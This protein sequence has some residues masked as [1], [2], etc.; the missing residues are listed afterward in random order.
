MLYSSF[1]LASYFT[2][3]SLC[4]SML[5]SQFVP[6]SLSGITFLWE[7]FSASGT[8]PPTLCLAISAP[9]SLCVPCRSDP[10]VLIQL[11][12]LP[13][14]L[15]V[16]IISSL[17]PQAYSHRQNVCVPPKFIYWHPNR[18]CQSVKILSDKENAYF[19]V[20]GS[21]SFFLCNTQKSWCILDL[22]KYHILK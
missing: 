13:R 2:N 1:P 8:V 3:G 7:A 18:Q 19:S 6:T 5:L 16:W 12:L 10:C 22:T 20:S 9:H 14:R 21:F 15:Q 4:M 11:E 17:L